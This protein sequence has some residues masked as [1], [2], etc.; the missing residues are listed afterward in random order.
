[1]TEARHGRWR[2]WGPD[3]VGVVWVLAAAAVVM[4]PALAHGASLGP[5]DLLSRYGLTRQHGVVVHDS[6]S[7]DQID[8]F[9]PWTSLAW[10]QVH[11]GSLPLWNPY[12]ALGLPLAFNWQSATFSLPAL[13]GYLVPLHLAYTVSVLVTL[14]IAGTGVYVLGRVLGLGVLGCTMAATVYELSGPFM[15]WLGWPVAGVMSWAGW[16]FAATV[17]VVRGRHRVRAIAACAVVVAWVLY[18]GQP[19]IVVLLGAALLVYLVVLLGLRAPWLGGSGPIRRPALDM[20]VALVAG[21]ALGAPILLPGAQIASGSIRRS[22]GFY[23]SLP[24]H[25]LIHILFQ[26]FDGLPVAGSRPFGGLNYVETAAY[27]GVIAV[28]LSVLAVAV[29]VRRRH[30]QTLAFGAVALSAMALAFFSP[31]VSVLFRVPLIG[32]VQWH[33]DLVSMAFGFAVLTGIGTDILVRSHGERTVR[34]WV[35]GGFAGSAVV[36]GALWL[37]GRGTL[38]PLQT[39]IREKSFIW[40]AV[41]IAVGLV[42]I[43]AVV[44]SGRRPARHAAVAS[45]THAGRWAAMV[46]IACETA[47]LVTAGAPLWSS[48][49]SYLPRTP[50]VEALQ[51]TVG[52]SLV[53]LGNLSCQP[54]PSLGILPNVN[55]AYDVHEFAA[56]D[57]V[58]PSA[59]FSYWKAATG[60]PGGFPTYKELCPAVTSATQGRRYG[61]AYV[62]E[63]KGDHGPKGAVFDTMVGNEKLYR[64]PGVAPATLSTLGPRGSLPGPDALGTAVGVTHP[65]DASWKLTTDAPGPRV[66]RLRLTDVPGWHASIDG[67]PLA[68]SQFSGFMLQARIPPGRHHIEL[69]YWPDTFTVGLVLAAVAVLGL[70]LALVIAGVRDRGQAAPTT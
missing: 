35:A 50:A 57:P 30:H 2:R 31:A 65:D 56:Y 45:V 24:G 62:L 47:F 13:V 38:H 26:G 53:G 15:G 9:I 70:L 19:E 10:T 37:V 69:H 66:L 28:V 51:R 27:V 7:S 54:F 6:L 42:A 55:I 14:A 40:P 18:A 39:S 3:V 11:H 67:H 29:A 12:T 22:V 63:S 43:G 36:V 17:L 25:D 16:L 23:G 58:I 1:M 49:P 34:K 32:R 44:W 59:Y 64:I 68:L 20:V 8:A 21:A 48:S 46:L 41:E 33:R 5:F 52:S 60:R 4:A 61:V